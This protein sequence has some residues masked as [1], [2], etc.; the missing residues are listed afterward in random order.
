VRAAQIKIITIMNK[1]AVIIIIVVIAAILGFMAWGYDRMA[2][3]T[4]AQLSEKS[5]LTASEV[6]YD[7][8]TISMASGTVDHKFQITNPTDK[9]ITITNLETSCMCTTAFFV[10]ADGSKTGPFGMP[11]MGGATA[12]NETIPAHGTQNIDVVFDPAAHGPAGVGDIDRTIDATEKD[13]GTLQL[14]IK[15]VVT[16]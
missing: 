9:D 16:P 10:N 13:G 4:T 5:S 15:A 14:E 11:G 12:A 2:G 6:L 7:F 1:K 3:P 8:G